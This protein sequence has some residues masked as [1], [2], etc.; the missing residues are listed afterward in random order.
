VQAGVCCQCCICV[1]ALHLG[2]ADHFEATQHGREASG[3]LLPMH[4]RLLVLR[5]VSPGTLT[6]M[7]CTHQ[8]GSQHTQRKATV[9]QAWYKW[10]CCVKKGFKQ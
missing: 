3:M 2:V 1:L 4:Y 9:R 7:T 6:G 10:L 8:Q 5:S